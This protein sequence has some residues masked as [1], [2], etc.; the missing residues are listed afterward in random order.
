MSAAHPVTRAYR[1]RAR[2]R[3]ALIIA[4][5]NLFGERGIDA[6]TIQDITDAADVGKGSFYYHFDSKE[7]VLQAA[8]ED[9]LTQFAARLDRDFDDGD[10]DPAFVLGYSLYRTLRLCLDDPAIGRF[11]LR[12]SDGVSLAEATI[13][14][15]ARRDLLQGR[16]AG[17]FVFDDVELV[18]TMITGGGIALLGRRLRDEL[19]PAAVTGYVVSSLRFLGVPAP[20]AHRIATEIEQRATPGRATQQAPDAEALPGSKAT[21]SEARPD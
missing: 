10:S 14:Q 16:E 21:R 11:V 4:A 13:G 18:F 8:A 20:E 17:R 3:S 12:I 7:E 1:R 15:S 2:T 19:T 5:R 6:V 9:V